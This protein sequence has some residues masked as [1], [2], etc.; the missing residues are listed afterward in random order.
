MQRKDNGHRLFMT[1][2][3]TE[4]GL[5]RQALKDSERGGPV[6]RLVTGEPG[7][8]RT[9]LL[10]AFSASSRAKGCLTVDLVCAPGERD[11]P[12][13]LA[14][15]LVRELAS[16]RLPAAERDGALGT[17]PPADGTPSPSDVRATVAG[18]TT[19]MPL[20]VTVDDADQADNASLEFLRH[21]LLSPPA[22]RLLLVASVQEGESREEAG[23]LYELL[24][25]ARRLRMEGLT[26]TQTA[27]LIRRALQRAPAPKLVTECHR[28]CAGNP[29]MLMEVARLIH[30]QPS[31]TQGRTLVGDMAP[32]PVAD[33][34][35]AR[36]A[37]IDPNAVRVA[38]AIA[39]AASNSAANPLLVA[40]LSGLSLHETLAAADL[41]VR[42]RLVE[43]DDK[44]FLRH[45][46]MRNALLGRMTLM[47]RNA[48]HLSAAA[49]LHDKHA[50]V[51][52]I[53]NHLT[54]ST[55][56]LDDP[57]PVPVLL[58]AGRAALAAREPERARAYLERAVQV[59][60]G[61][62]RRSALLDLT[63]ARMRIDLVGGLEE[64]VRV[65]EE[66]TGTAEAAQAAESARATRTAEDS[67]MSGPAGGPAGDDI[68]FPLLARVS[69]A[70]Y[71][72]AQPGEGVRAATTTVLARSRLSGWP[73]LHRILDYLQD[74]PPLI[75]SQPGEQLLV[76]KGHTPGGDAAALGADLCGPGQIRAAATVVGALRSHLGEDGSYSPDD[77]VRQA[78]EALRTDRGL[79]LYPLLTMTALMILVWNGRDEEAAAHLRR[80]QDCALCPEHP[81][82]RTF[83]LPVTARM[84]LV[85]G[86]L[87]AAHDE[88]GECLDALVRYETRY[89]H[90][91]LVW[92]VGMLADVKI[93]MGLDGEA[94]ALLR[95]HG[96][97]GSLPPGWLYRDLLVTRARLRAG[98]GDL[99]G[100]SRD[101]T[102]AWKSGA[103]ARG[104]GRGSPAH[105]PGAASDG[106]DVPAGIA[107][108]PAVG[109]GT[110]AGAT[111]GVHWYVYGTDLLAQF[112]QDEDARSMARELVRSAEAVNAPRELG[113]ALR[114]LGAVHKGV[115][116]EKPLREAVLLLT[117]TGAE[118]DLAQAAADL[119][120]LLFDEG[121]HEEAVV[122]LSTALE[123]ADRCG[124]RPLAMRLRQRLAAAEGRASQRSPL[125]GVL[126]LT[127]REKQILIDAV[128]G[129][130]NERI[131]TTLH[132]TRRTVELHLS[133][134]YRKL[135]ITGRK[136]FPNLFRTAGLWPLLVD[137]GSLA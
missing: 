88:L 130:T 121:R 82:H 49:Y 77:A 41:L 113:V 43:D 5:L 24:A 91:I 62:E 116:A 25:G 71:L 100:A 57:W 20:V 8:G 14:R 74:Y 103:P 23:Q 104:H 122:E 75:S 52:Q 124:A 119:A 17:V 63:D 22:A 79:C 87:R 59:A 89:Q 15:Q 109:G 45:H 61:A 11:R 28:V 114:V 90:P 78:Q 33:L 9:T 83:L 64:A 37:K 27:T 106:R 111:G 13:S 131:A 73:L 30:D 31:D 125:G 72:R 105:G 66:A 32:S 107:S 97:L 40:H 134:A 108:A 4:M 58:L 51:E 36:L 19:T 26:R 44:L 99:A 69:T 133:S 16:L 129:L 136:D 60:S 95:E 50:P 38:T 1:G 39:I 65:L 94:R 85:R 3:Q 110:P 117:E 35:G 48:A 54:A 7:I 96:C 118:F 127:K 76:P 21:A 84:A 2:R 137:T 93:S 126:T 67:A 132:I 80:H 53:A 135:G 81:M 128:R 10:R 29:F 102:E 115:E 55:V 34:I 56:A 46:V 47:G 70:L 18:L 12:L 68:R 42:T 6:R 86:R 123:M 120:C 101:L 112:G 98:G 92:V